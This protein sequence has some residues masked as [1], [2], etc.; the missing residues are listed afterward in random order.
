MNFVSVLNFYTKIRFLYLI[1]MFIN[2]FLDHLW[3][4]TFYF[5]YVDD[6]LLCIKNE[7]LNTVLDVF[8]NYNP[9]LSFS[10]ELE[11]NNSINFLYITITR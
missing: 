4:R 1:K 6:I 7:H 8:N 3:D 5:R 11:Q 9:H 10:R 2:K